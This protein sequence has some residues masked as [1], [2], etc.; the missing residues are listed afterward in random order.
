[1]VIDEQGFRENVCIVLSDGAGRVFWAR[2]VFQTDAWQFPQGGI[3]CN[4]AH[5]DAMFRELREETGLLA[6][7]V[8]IIACTRGWL[9]YRLP[10]KFIRYG[11]Q[12]LCIGQKQIWYLLKLVAGEQNINLQ[13][14]DKPEFD[15][16]K[17]VKYW[18]PAQEV[19]SFKRCVYQQALKE[20]EPALFA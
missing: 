8:K 1:M 11:S 7:H 20:L 2:R 5:E 4:E 14:F 16:W 13:Y 9:R 3:K 12:P 19:V 10:K 18:S 6:E 15:A 17:W